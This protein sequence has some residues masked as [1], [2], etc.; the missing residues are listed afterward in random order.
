MDVKI[1]NA[2]SATLEDD[3]IDV[4]LF[5]REFSIWKS[6]DEYGSYLF[7]KDSS[8]AKPSI[9]GNPSALRHVHLVPLADNLALQRWDRAWS[10]SARKTS[11][12]AL[13]YADAGR[14]RYLL[15]FILPEPDAHII[16]SMQTQQAKETMTGFLNVASEF[17]DTG[18]III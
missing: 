10:R 16:A 13:V 7:G 12:R 1:T 4:D 5:I 2:L 11:D 8:Y 6:G 9:F 18:K 15:I 17:I 3:E 14:G